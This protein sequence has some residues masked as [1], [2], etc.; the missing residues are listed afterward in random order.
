E[1]GRLTDGHHDHD[2]GQRAEVL[3][4]DRRVEQHPHR[5]EEQ[6][7][8]EVAE[9]NDVAERLMPVLRFS[10]RAVA[11]TTR[12]MPPAGRVNS[13]NTIISGTTARSWTTRMPSMTRLDS[14][15]SRPCA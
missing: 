5:D 13:G 6:H 12:M 8:E 4:D 14:V 11:A 2:H 3:P 9:R 1:N 15:P 10:A 7:A